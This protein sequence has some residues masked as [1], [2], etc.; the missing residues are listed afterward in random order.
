MMHGRRPKRTSIGAGWGGE[1]ESCASALGSVCFERKISRSQRHIWK[2]HA[3][4]GATPCLKVWT[5][6]CTKL[7]VHAPA[8]I[9]NAKVSMVLSEPWQHSETYT[10]RRSSERRQD[11]RRGHRP[12][13]SAHTTTP[14]G[15]QCEPD[16]VFM[17]AGRKG[18]DGTVTHPPAQPCL[19]T[20]PFFVARS[21]RRLC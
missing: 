16:E 6:T 20:T 15:A 2:S 1:A 8:T 5:C 4:E 3:V 21:A 12:S 17:R 9:M 13:A 11:V 7:E 19:P 10:P 14:R 18:W